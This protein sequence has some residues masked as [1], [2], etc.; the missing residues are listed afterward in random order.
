MRCRGYA[1]SHIGNS[2]ENHEDN[3]LLGKL[4]ACRIDKK[5][6]IIYLEKFALENSAVTGCDKISTS[7]GTD[8]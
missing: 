5:T 2:R 4:F 8:T 3:Y 1:I 7:Q 6:K